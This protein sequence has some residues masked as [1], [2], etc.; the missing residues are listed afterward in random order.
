MSGL[1]TRRVIPSAV[2]AL[3]T[4]TWPARGRAALGRARGGRARLE[5]FFA[6]DDPCSAVAV[7]EIVVAC[8]ARPVDVVLLPVVQRGIP[9]DPAVSDKRREA[10]VDARRRARRA[11]REILRAEPLAPGDTA[12]LARWAAAAPQ[13]PRLEAFC[14]RALAALWFETAGPVLEADYAAIWRAELH[15][16]PVSGEGAALRAEA[17]M[18]RRGPYDVPAAVAGGRWFFAHD[19]PEQV[20]DWLDELGWGVVA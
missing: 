12:F 11:S 4:V 16:P 19:R 1:V 17:L 13:G 9:G 2:I 8:A 10:L 6:F 14:L 20:G 5:L 3:S 18:R 7:P 15:G